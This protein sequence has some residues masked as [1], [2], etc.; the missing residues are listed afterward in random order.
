MVGFNTIPQGWMLCDGS[1]LQIEDYSE[2]YQMIKD[3]YE[4]TSTSSFNLPNFSSKQI[5]K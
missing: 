2:L 3:N 1:S 4:S 5:S